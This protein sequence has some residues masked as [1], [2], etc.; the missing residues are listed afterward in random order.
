MQNFQNFIKLYFKTE[1]KGNKKKKKNKHNMQFNYA[2]NL[3]YLIPNNVQEIYNVHTQARAESRNLKGKTYNWN[4]ELRSK[5][6]K[7]KSTC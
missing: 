3:F 5:Q 2:Q 1:R 6:Y 7:S 4:M